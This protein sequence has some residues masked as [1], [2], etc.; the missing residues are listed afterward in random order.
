MVD[1][2]FT[3]FLKGEQET[4][5]IL[6][7]NRQGLPL[8]ASPM[9]QSRYLHHEQVCLSTRGMPIRS[10]PKATKAPVHPHSHRYQHG[11][12]TTTL[13]VPESVPLDQVM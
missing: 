8:L 5:S 2:T 6:T 4:S 13:P 7:P 11:D 3:D 10:T 1:T 9:P 12:T